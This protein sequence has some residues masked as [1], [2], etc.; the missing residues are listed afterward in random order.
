MPSGGAAEPRSKS[1]MPQRT[2]VR[3]RAATQ[4]QDHVV[5]ACAIAEPW[6]PNRFARLGSRD[7]R[8]S[9]AA[10]TSGASW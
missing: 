1:A 10:W 9:T 5:V 3:D 4:R 8:R 2:C 6:P 7:R